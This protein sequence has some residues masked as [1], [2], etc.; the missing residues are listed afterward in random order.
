MGS[1]QSTAA[2]SG[3]DTTECTHY[4]LL[5]VIGALGSLGSLIGTII[6]LKKRCQNRRG[7][8]VADNTNNALVL[9]ND[10]EGIELFQQPSLVQYR[11]TPFEEL[12]YHQKHTLG[13]NDRKT[14]AI[15]PRRSM[16]FFH[17]PAGLQSLNRRSNSFFNSPNSTYT[18]LR[19]QT[20]ECETKDEED[21]DHVCFERFDQLDPISEDL[22][23][24]SIYQ[25]II[26][27]VHPTSGATQNLRLPLQ[28]WSVNEYEPVKVRNRKQ[29]FIAEDTELSKIKNLFSVEGTEEMRR[30]NSLWKDR[31]DGTN[32]IHTAI[33]LK[34]G[35]RA[36]RTISLTPQQAEDSEWRFQSKNFA[37]KAGNVLEKEN[38]QPQ[39]IFGQCQKPSITR[40]ERNEEL[41]TSRKAT[42]RQPMV[43]R[44]V[45]V[46]SQH[47]ENQH[48]PNNDYRESLQ[49]DNDGRVP[50]TPSSP[51]CSSE[52]VL[53]TNST[54]RFAFST[55]PMEVDWNTG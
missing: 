27:S 30:P 20:N 5:L 32:I 34:E 54:G 13:S 26:D 9:N 37:S 49:C 19:R 15:K 29:D 35:G 51:Q 36:S 4:F 6:L 50:R 55:T 39:N 3:A 43:N 28:A 45:E 33:S 48:P 53:S 21:D 2:C 46:V 24:I 40:N 14:V 12:Q 23:S 38:K 17:C 44:Q 47:L 10:M 1:S 31:L 7:H 8:E 42:I 18:L 16:L 11:L 52:T 41:I 25:E 22:Q